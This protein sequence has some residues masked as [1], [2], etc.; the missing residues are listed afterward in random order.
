M[1]CDFHSSGVAAKAV[2]RSKDHKERR[3]GESVRGGF[4]LPRDAFLQSGVGGMVT[5][6]GKEAYL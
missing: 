1:D 3:I 6:P 5:L 2:P 4:L